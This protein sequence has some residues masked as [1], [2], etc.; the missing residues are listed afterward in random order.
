MSKNNKTKKIINIF[1]RVF[2]VLA[3]LGG[4][5]VGGFFILDRAVVPSY[6]GKYGIHNLSDLVQMVKVMHNAPDEKVFITHPYTKD[7]ET[8]VVKRLKE[9]GVPVEN[10][11]IVFSEIVDGNFTIT[12]EAKKGVFVSDYE[13]AAVLGQM[14]ESG[15]LVSYLKDLSYFDTLSFEAK[16]IVLTPGEPTKTT[17]ASTQYSS[18]AHVSLTIKLNTTNAQKHMAK[19]MDVPLFLLDMI[20]PNYLYIT[21]TYD[22]KILDNNEYEVTNATLGI[23]GR[24]PKQS[25]ILLN[26]LISFIFPAEDEMTPDKLS[27]KFGDI[28]NSGL[29][30]LGDVQFCKE[31]TAAGDQNGIFVSLN[32]HIETEEPT[33]QP[34]NP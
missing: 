27:E 22:L 16:E 30:I 13:L 14:L 8:A 2:I 20:L 7:H 11:K 5:G 34:E 25:S 24:T 21:S 3:V 23:N 32:P 28:L 1:V 17:E 4:I 29:K 33:P 9:A 26:I 31:T 19:E 12:E 10:G 6:F 15:Y 18:S